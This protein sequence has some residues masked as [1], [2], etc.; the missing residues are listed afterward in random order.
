MKIMRIRTIPIVVVLLILA[1]RLGVY[2][3]MAGAPEP[4]GPPATTF[5]YSLED[6]YQRLDTGAAGSTSAFTEPASGPGTGTGHTLDEVMAKAP[7]ADNA[8]GAVPAEVLTGM[9][10]WGLRTD[11][12]WG[13][14]TGMVAAGENIS[15]TDGLK[16]FP[17]PDGLYSGSKQATANDKDLVAGNIKSGVDIL[18]VTGS[19]P[20]APVRRTGQDLCYDSAG[21]TCACGE[22]GCPSGQDGDQKKGIVWPNP[23]FTSNVDSN[24]DGDCD[25]AG[26]TCDGTV[27]DNLT[28]LI[29]LR[30]ADCRDVMSW[31]EALALAD[32]LYDGWTGDGSGGDCELADG[33][34]TGD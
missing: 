18:G 3:G 30:K 12:T 10:Y 33:S 5:S 21:S 2:A 28:G 6:I 20:P 31:E 34:E 26:E 15:G 23:R 16:T 17:I 7:V 8:K 1:F 4:P 11:G 27:T 22:L 32:T 14:Q 13:L 25:D 9:T 24:G 29:W 19:Y